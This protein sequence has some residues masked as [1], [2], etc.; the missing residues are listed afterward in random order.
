VRIQV[1]G[2]R[3]KHECLTMEAVFL[4]ELF[5]AMSHSICHFLYH[6]WR[7]CF[8]SSA[9][10]HDRRHRPLCQTKRHCAFTGRTKNNER[11]CPIFMLRVIM[12]CS[13]R[14]CSS[15]TNANPASPCRPVFPTKTGQNRTGFDLISPARTLAAYCF[16][17]FTFSQTSLWSSLS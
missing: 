7:H 16:C 8:F 13:R 12:L 3:E 1:D 14:Q 4:I 9:M 6:G 17:P 15:L 11:G 2:E 5:I 10:L